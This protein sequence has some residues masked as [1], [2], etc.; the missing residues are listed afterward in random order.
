MVSGAG[1]PSANGFYRLAEQQVTYEANGKTR[2]G[3]QWQQVDSP[4]WRI[5]VSDATA[6]PPEDAG[7]GKEKDKDG[8]GAG[9]VVWHICKVTMGREQEVYYT[10]PNAE[11]STPKLGGGGYQGGR[12]PPPFG[13]ACGGVY[14]AG[15]P[16]EEE[17]GR[18]EVANAMGSARNIHLSVDTDWAKRGDKGSGGGGGGGG[19]KDADDS[20]SYAYADADGNKCEAKE[21][22]SA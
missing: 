9:V 18:L 19:E 22:R 6:P 4:A 11:P 5:L 10:S 2:Q 17:D 8:G 21:P 3:P 13:W 20:Y 12:R 14:G 7:G 1:S 15:R 16:C